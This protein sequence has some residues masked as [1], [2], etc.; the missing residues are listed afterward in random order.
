MDI[1]FIFKK[2]QIVLL[3]LFIQIKIF[4]FMCACH[5]FFD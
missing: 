1:S 2:V 5:A 3:N 4:I